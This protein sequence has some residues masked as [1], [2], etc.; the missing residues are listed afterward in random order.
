L[1][2][3]KVLQNETSKEIAK[4][5]LTSVDALLAPINPAAAASKKVADVL[6]GTS[7]RTKGGKALQDFGTYLQNKQA[8]PYQ[9]LMKE[10]VRQQGDNN[11]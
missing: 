1:S 10:A 11:E 8:N 7:A 9:F 3:Q 6:K 5:A 4:N 2:S